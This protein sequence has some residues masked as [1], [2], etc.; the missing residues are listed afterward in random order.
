MVMDYH[1][2]L[3]FWRCFFLFVFFVLCM[4]FT[5]FSYC[6][7]ACLKLEEYHT[8]KAAL[9][10]GAALTQNDSRFKKLINECDQRIAGI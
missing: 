2:A 8:A 1:I 7:T 10:T 6:S 9:E 5:H 4:F 3:P